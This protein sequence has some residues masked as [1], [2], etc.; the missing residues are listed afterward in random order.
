MLFVA[1]ESS[2]LI[3]EKPD[4]IIVKIFEP[5]RIIVKILEPDRIIVKM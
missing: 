5:E 4:K 3:W 1:K 2:A